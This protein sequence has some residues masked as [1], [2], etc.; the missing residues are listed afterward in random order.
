MSSRGV[1]GVHIQ[2]PVVIRSVSTCN[3]AVLQKQQPAQVQVRVQQ[4]ITL[5]EQQQQKQQK[6]QQQTT[7]VR[8]SFTTATTTVVADRTSGA[9]CR[10]ESFPRRDRPSA[11]SERDSSRRRLNAKVDPGNCMPAL[12]QAGTAV[13]NKID[14][15]Q[16]ND[17]K[18]MLAL[19]SDDERIE[20]L[21]LDFAF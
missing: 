1:A 11:N 2:Q 20:D 18:R 7:V 5:Q 8:R 3:G 21:S 4:P 16:K 17:K 6:Q 13:P 15:C 10:S 12:L 14:S 9:Q 19:F